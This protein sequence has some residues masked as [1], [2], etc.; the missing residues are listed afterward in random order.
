MSLLLLGGKWNSHVNFSSY[1][2]IKSLMG[3]SVIFSLQSQHQWPFQSFNF[4]CLMISLLEKAEKSL[5]L[6]KEMNKWMDKVNCMLEPAKPLLVI[7]NTSRWEVAS[8]LYCPRPPR[9][10]S[11]RASAGGQCGVSPLLCLRTPVL[12]A[13]GSGC[14]CG[15]WWLCAVLL[16]LDSPV[17]ACRSPRLARC[18]WG[19]VSCVGTLEF[20]GAVPVCVCRLVLLLFCQAGSAQGWLPA[21]GCR[22][23][24]VILPLQPL[25]DKSQDIGDCKEGAKLYL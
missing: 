2:E 7:L 17:C 25:G 4:N 12:A 11:R 21:Q 10:Q 1:H 9:A 19:L 3:N 6:A 5:F 16:A 8:R 15:H 24:P 14:G 13:L 23:D 22:S 20:L 18:H